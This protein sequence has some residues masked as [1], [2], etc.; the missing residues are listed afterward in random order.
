MML[1]K[2]LSP[3]KKDHPEGRSFLASYYVQTFMITN[4]DVS[5]SKL[6]VRETQMCKAQTFTCVKRNPDVRS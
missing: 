3:T 4:P 1:E 5:C 2:H 6:F